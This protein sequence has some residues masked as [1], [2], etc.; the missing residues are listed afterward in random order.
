MKKLEGELARQHE[1][2]IELTA[3]LRDSATVEDLQQVIKDLEAQLEHAQASQQ[4]AVQRC[5]QLE[6]ELK[7]LKTLEEVFFLFVLW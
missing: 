4:L 5:H 6:D 7:N 2:N 3:E 1:A